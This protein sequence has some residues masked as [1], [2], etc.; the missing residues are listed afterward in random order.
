MPFPF[1]GDLLNWG[2]EQTF[3]S[4]WA[5]ESITNENISNALAHLSNNDNYVDYVISHCPPNIILQDIENEF[6]QCGEEVPYY[7]APQAKQT[8][9]EYELFILSFKNSSHS[10]K[11]KLVNCLGIFTFAES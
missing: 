1:P 6:T 9:L 11:Y 10:L 3:L 7:I 2:I 5:N 4:W 8:N